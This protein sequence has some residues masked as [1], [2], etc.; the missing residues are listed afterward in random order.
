MRSC[1][2]CFLASLAVSQG[3]LS[4]DHKAPAQG[5]ERAV[6]LRV[7]AP[8]SQGRQL[9]DQAPDGR[10]LWAQH[11]VSPGLAGDAPR[12]LK[13]WL[14]R[15]G[16]PA[17]ALALSAQDARLHPTAPKLIAW[18]SAQG[19]LKEGP[20]EAPMKAKVVAQA[21]QFA[22]LSYAQGS[23]RLVFCAGQAPMFDV[24]VRE[25]SG[26]LVR[27]TRQAA[28]RWMPFFGPQGKEV[29]VSQGQGIVRQ[30]APL[31]RPEPWLER[32]RQPSLAPSPHFSEG[33]LFG[34]DSR[35]AFAL[36]AKGEEVAR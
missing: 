3:C 21:P 17:R 22:G 33:V 2:L 14:E 35:G 5:A 27:W 4:E 6:A 31:A 12:T 7:T 24:F 26:Q 19:E 36:N 25:P 34:H 13:L 10:L 16:E 20:Y 8:D 28:P 23:D 1:Y 18:T 9:L 15:P 11:E 32:A 30:G 29:Y